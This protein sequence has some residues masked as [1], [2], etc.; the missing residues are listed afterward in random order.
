MENEFTRVWGT[1]KLNGQ[2]LGSS[3]VVFLETKDKLRVPGQKTQVVTIRQRNLRFV[4][5]HSVVFVGSTIKFVNDDNEV[6]NIYSKS[7]SNQFNLGAMAAG[8]SKVI[9]VE[10]AGPIVLRCNI[11]K[12][13]VGT[14]FVVPNGY[15]TAS[16]KNGEFEFKSVKS[17]EYFLQVWH[18]QLYPEEVDAAMKSI[19]LTGRDVTYDFDIKSQSK[20]GEIHDMVDK[21]DYDTIVTNIEKLLYD[22]ITSWIEGNK[23]KPRKQ[24]L[25]AITKHYDGEGLKGAIAKSFNEKRSVN[26]EEKLDAI[27]KKLSGIIKDESMTV[28]SLKN[29]AAFVISRLRFNVRELKARVAPVQPGKP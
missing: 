6:H 17:K 19:G 16:G 28:E 15:Y 2:P 24:I 27:R 13:M 11:H 12:D 26:L 25:I 3:T 14:L 5:R 10:D 22:A 23:Y 4:P 1:V 9:M 29:E 7:L 21:T 20:S 8:S 18:P